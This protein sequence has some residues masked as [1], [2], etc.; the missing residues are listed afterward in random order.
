VLNYFLIVLFDYDGAAIATV[1]SNGLLAVVHI[2]FSKRLVKYK[3]VFSM[4]M[5]LPA[6]GGLAIA[7]ILFY[8]CTELWA[9]R[10]LIAFLV[11]GYMLIKIYRNKSVF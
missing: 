7:T 6:A 9:I 10:W 1:I 5:F 2:I 8:V 4:N 11:G 3:W